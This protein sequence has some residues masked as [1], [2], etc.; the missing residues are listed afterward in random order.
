MRLII[1]YTLVYTLIV[2]AA[3]LLSVPVVIGEAAQWLADR[4]VSRALD[5]IEEW[6]DR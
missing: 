1:G 2:P 3:L 6:M 4:T 5:C